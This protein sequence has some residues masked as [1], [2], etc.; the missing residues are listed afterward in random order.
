MHSEMAD[1]FRIRFA[2]L[3]DS[4]VISWHRARMFEDMGEL[5]ANLFEA[6]R[7]SSCVRLRN[8]LARGDYVGWLLSLE[9]APN[10]IIAGAGVHLRRVLPHPSDNTA[11]FADGRHGIIV[12][13]FTEPEWRRKGLAG[14]LL[15]RIID[16]ARDEKLDRLL[17]HSSTDG[18]ALYERLGFVATN[19]MR[20]AGDSPPK[21]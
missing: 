11:T 19:E 3:H 7:A 17:L 10:K 13:V 8:L 14:M 20:F 18:R 5:P 16:W 2:T 12:N 1:K 6:F 9:N 21:T 4:E 15:N